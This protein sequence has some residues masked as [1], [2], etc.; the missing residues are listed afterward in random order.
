MIDIKRKNKVFLC[1][2]KTIAY[3]CKQ[4]VIAYEIDI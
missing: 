3:I 1:Q 4:M 2:F